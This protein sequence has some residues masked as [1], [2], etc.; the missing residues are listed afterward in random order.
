MNPLEYNVTGIDYAERRHLRYQGRIIDIHAHVMV[1]RPGDP[2]SGPPPGTGPGATVMQ[3]E[4]MLEVA[5]EFG[6][7]QVATMPNDAS[8][9]QRFHLDFLPFRYNVTEGGRRTSSR[10]SLY[11]IIK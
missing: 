7:V 11:E 5:S 8:A 2:M 6:I 1:T 9:G 4:T 10:L 3:A